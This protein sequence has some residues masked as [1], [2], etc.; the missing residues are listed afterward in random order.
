MM[1]KSDDISGKNRACNSLLQPL[2]R[3]LVNRIVPKVPKPIET[4][5][6]TLMS[7]PWSISMI[8]VGFLASENKWWLL[9]VTGLILLQYITDVLDGAVGR[10]RQTGL[11]KWGFYMDH[12]LDYLFV[13][14]TVTA[15]ALAFHFPLEIYVVAS[16]IASGA[17]VHTAL[18]AIVKGEYNI[19]GHYGIGSTEARVLVVLLNGILPWFSGEQLLM[20]MSIL[21]PVSISVFV[22][23]IYHSAKKLWWEEIKR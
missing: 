20:F 23:V 19:S 7:I 2:E 6:L 5:H 8:V 9:A 17:F 16:L 22:L 4:Y 18:Y 12:F 1:M 3:Y 14:A 21:I 11:I 10:Y 15:Y 13:C